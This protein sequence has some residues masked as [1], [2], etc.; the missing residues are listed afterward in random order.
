MR[1]ALFNRRLRAEQKEDADVEARIRALADAHMQAAASAAMSQHDMQPAQPAY[2][3]QQYQQAPVQHGQRGADQYT[4]N[5]SAPPPVPSMQDTYPAERAPQQHSP[6]QDTSSP[7]DSKRRSPSGSTRLTSAASGGA[8]VP[9]KVV[10]RSPMYR[11]ASPSRKVGADAVRISNFS[12]APR[13]K[14]KNGWVPGPG[15]YPVHATT[16]VFSPTTVREQPDLTG[17]QGHTW[18]EYQEYVRG[19]SSQALVQQDD[20][21]SR[22]AYQDAMMSKQTSP[23]STTERKLRSELQGLQRSLSQTQGQSAQTQHQM[24]AEIES[25]KARLSRKSKAYTALGQKVRS[26]RDNFGRLQAA[27]AR[28]QTALD[29]SIPNVPGDDPLYPLLR[30]VN[31]RAR[32][33][34]EQVASLAPFVHETASAVDKSQG[35]DSP[36]AKQAAPKDS[37]TQEARR[38]DTVSLRLTHVSAFTVFFVPQTRSRSSPGCPRHSPLRCRQLR[39][40]SPTQRRRAS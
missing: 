30:E 23:E 35:I 29:A 24:F 6:R 4:S 31:S 15:H 40:V 5:Y 37:P 18:E 21:R 2:S 38:Y 39:S 10:Y 19:G 22:A 20:V 16:S 1:H 33:V 17:T 34:G 8:A 36:G 3:Q 13:F 27:A 11:S 28:L 26:W 9:S 25:L 7:T 32:E 14:T 12:R